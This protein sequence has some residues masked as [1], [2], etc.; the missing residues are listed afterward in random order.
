MDISQNTN[1]TFVDCMQKHF[2]GILFLTA[3]L[4]FM[5]GNVLTMIFGFGL[6][7]IVPLLLLISPPI[8]GLMIIY[9][10]S[11]RKDGIK[12]TLKVLKV[13]RIILIIFLVFLC[14]SIPLNLHTLFTGGNFVALGAF[15][16]LIFTIP[17]IIFF[18]ALFRV[19]RCIGHRLERNEQLRRGFDA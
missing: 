2:G 6:V 15:Y 14:I 12:Y 5:V 4:L 3:I 8:T 1:N 9:F 19:V 11:K 7:G 10:E 18:I 13:F 16:T 17:E